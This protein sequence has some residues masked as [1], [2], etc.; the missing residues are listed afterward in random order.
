M[1][2]IRHAAWLLVLAAGCWLVL[3]LGTLSQGHSMLGLP[4]DWPRW[5]L[6]LAQGG[7]VAGVFMYARVQ[8]DALR[9]H[10][11]LPLL[12]RLFWR[13]LVLTALL[14]GV[15]VFTRMAAERTLPL[16]GN[17]TAAAGYTVSLGLFIVLLA[18]TLYIWRSLVNFRG[19][20]R[21]RREWTAFELILGAALLFQLF[22]WDAPAYLLVAAVTGLGLFGVYLSGHQ[23]WVAYL[24]QGQKLQAIMLQL[25]VLGCLLAFLYVL[26]GAQHDPSLLAPPTQQ[27]FLVLTS[28]FA[29]FYAL[30]GL[31]VT[32]FNLPIADVYEQRRAEILS[33]QQLSQI[34][35]RGQTA[36]EIYQALFT[37]AVQ[38]I[39]ADAGWL[40]AQP[41]PT[42]QA[43]PLPAT[44]TH[45][46]VP[47]DLAIMRGQLPLLLA[48]GQTEITDNDLGRSQRLP[49]LSQPYG[50]AA[51]LA[52]RSATHDY[53][54]L[55]LLK[56]EQSGFDPEDLSILHTFTTQTVLSLENLQLA[57]EARISQ[58]AQDELRI[59]ALVQ[60]RLIPKHLPTDNWFEISTYAQAA[61]EV[62]GDFYDFLHLPGQR[63]AVLIGDVSGKG[64]TA[65][66][67]TAQMKGIFHALMQPNPLAKKDRDRYPDPHRFMVKANEALTH[68]LER[69]SFITASFYLIDYEAGGFS[70]AR[71]GHCHT[72][73][74]H[75]IKEE[76]SY[77]RSEGLGL[78]ILRDGSYSRH[79]KNQFWDY[80]PGDVMVIYTDGI[81]EARNASG[82][83]Y[84]EERLAQ[85]LGESFYQSAE[86]INQHIR[87]DVQE[88]SKGLPLHD[89]QTLLVI[90]F[91]SAQPQ[92]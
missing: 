50:S 84:G 73:Y 48:D 37:S 49:G 20:D 7:F 76:V 25:G 32:L 19:S 70:F 79:V 67:H 80:N 53:G 86:E 36:P 30:A 56:K 69:S 5:L 11:F 51:V 41:Q 55:M 66:F 87:H 17:A 52:L 78:G 26:R 68:C 15:Q 40:D 82:D 83:E 13:G 62:G 3:L 16:P 39:R 23:R 60:E 58:S 12:R 75:S 6:L 21:L 42:E 2:K 57:Q 34:I 72:L 47:A 46:L 14:A 35:Q 65:A 74:Y 4:P 45:E 71:A 92:G 8:P 64:V 29:V 10:G 63:L 33:L 44:L 22:V 77:F 43:G 38:T 81:P 61:K 24:S 89:D 85:M 90:K 54:V 91:K 18:Q 59:A 28:S 31:L 88:F 27:A 1:P 9:G